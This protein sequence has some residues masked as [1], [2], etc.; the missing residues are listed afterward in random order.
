MKNVITK[1]ALAKTAIAASKMKKEGYNEYSKY[2]YFTPEQIKAIAHEQCD[3]HGLFTKFD[4]ERS[5][6]GVH[7]TLTIIDIETMEAIVYKAA[8]EIPA[9]TATNA[10]QQ[11][12]GAMTFSE[13]YLIQ[14]AFG[15]ADNSLDPDSKD[16]TKTPDNRNNDDKPWLN[17]Y[18]RSGEPT[19]TL[20]KLRQELD[21]GKQFTLAAIRSKY[22]VSKTV[23][24][25]LA[26]L[27]IK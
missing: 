10:A 27:N 16:N 20:V 9:I 4:M 23:Q 7:S 18:T 13:R 8:T 24:S 14:F 12:G 17:L 3:K 1:L 6:H 2:H 21:G 11:H 19:E 5:E 25:E 15:M 26:D 22:K